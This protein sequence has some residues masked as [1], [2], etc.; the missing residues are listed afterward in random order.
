LLDASIDSQPIGLVLAIVLDL[1]LLE[2]LDEL[3]IE[4]ADLGA[5]E[6]TVLVKD[7]RQRPTLHLAKAAHKTAGAVLS[8]HRYTRTHMCV[9]LRA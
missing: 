5:S 7:V 6:A 3:L 9:R 4:N 2:Q 1:V 8:I